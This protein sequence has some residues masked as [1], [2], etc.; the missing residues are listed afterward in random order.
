MM[1][2][3]LYSSQIVIFCDILIW[4]EYK[5]KQHFHKAVKAGVMVYNLFVSLG[6]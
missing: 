2:Q 4:D 5:G 3:K 6:V 1:G